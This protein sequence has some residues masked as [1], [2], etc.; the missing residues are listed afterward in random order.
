MP[1]DSEKVMEYIAACVFGS[2]CLIFMTIAVV[3]MMTGVWVV[4]QLFF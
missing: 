4:I 1:F 2:C 3:V